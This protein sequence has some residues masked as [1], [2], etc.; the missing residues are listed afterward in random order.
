MSDEQK[1][2]GENGESNDEDTTED[3]RDRSRRDAIEDRFKQGL[4]MLGAMRDAIED[5]IRDIKER[6]DLAPDRAKEVVRGALDKAQQ[7]AE[8]AREA[9][10]FVKQKEFDGLKSVVDDLASRLGIVEE[11][12][13]INQDET[14]EEGS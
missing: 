6:G 10:D 2:A 3:T 7:K 4:G 9:L 5:T 12:A 11:K 13:G 14:E 8:E 1:P